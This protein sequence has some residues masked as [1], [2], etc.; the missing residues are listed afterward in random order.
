MRSNHLAVIVSWSPEL[1]TENGKKSSQIH[2]I[3][4]PDLNKNQPAS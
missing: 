2:I 4:S 1:W 3:N